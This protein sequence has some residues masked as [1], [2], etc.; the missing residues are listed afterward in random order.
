MISAQVLSILRSLERDYRQ[1]VLE[2]LASQ[3]RTVPTGVDPL[4]LAAELSS[5]DESS[6]IGQSLNLYSSVLWCVHCRQ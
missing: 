1:A 4:D 5:E 6:D 2:R 3:G